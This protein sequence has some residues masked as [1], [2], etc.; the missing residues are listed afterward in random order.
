MTEKNKQTLVY[1][2]GD[3]TSQ[4]KSSPF[5]GIA[6][7]LTRKFDWDVLN[8][9]SRTGL[10]DSPVVSRHRIKML[11]TADLAI[12]LPG[13]NRSPR[14]ILEWVTVMELKIDFCYL[15]DVLPAVPRG[16]AWTEL[17]DF[18]AGHGYSVVKHDE[19]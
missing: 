12:I 15:A 11:L 14:A 1:L 7:D 2:I 17:L 18:L 19:S 16:D 5:R 6:D 10:D 9:S 3:L 8:G 13:W 4:Q